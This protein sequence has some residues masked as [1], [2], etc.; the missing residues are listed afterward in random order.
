MITRANVGTWIPYHPIPL[1]WGAKEKRTC[2]IRKKKSV[3]IDTI[4]S[5]LPA[6][7][8][9]S[10][11]MQDPLFVCFLIRSHVSDDHRWKLCNS[12]H[13]RNWVI[14]RAKIALRSAN[15]KVQWCALFTIQCTEKEMW[16]RGLKPF[17]KNITHFHGN[18]SRSQ[19]KDRTGHPTGEGCVRP[20]QDPTL[21]IP[22]CLQ[23]CSAA[24][25]SVCVF[26]IEW[27]NEEIREAL[28]IKRCGKK[29]KTATWREPECTV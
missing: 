5:S 19:E 17:V 2:L 22:W 1:H 14:W 6:L 26:W 25:E 10:F 28:Q 27:G 3:N 18:F 7:L 9:A 23:Q 12:M 29:S 21:S 24:R 11:K 13:R 4:F 15:D 20:S 8:D 16:R